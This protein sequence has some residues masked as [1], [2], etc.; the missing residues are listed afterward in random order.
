[1]YIWDVI[2]GKQKMQLDV[3]ISKVTKIIVNKYVRN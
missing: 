2:T 3:L 1:M